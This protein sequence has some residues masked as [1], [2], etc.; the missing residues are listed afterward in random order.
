MKPFFFYFLK[1]ILEK[2]NIKIG[3]LKPE[4]LRGL[5]MKETI[6]PAM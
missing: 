5:T 3:P 2:T 1:K 4:S 6:D